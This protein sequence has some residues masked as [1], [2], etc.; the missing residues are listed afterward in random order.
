MESLI[1]N[2]CH[3]VGDDK[4][5]KGWISKSSRTYARHA[6]RNGDR[7][8]CI[9]IMEGTFTNALHTIGNESILAAFY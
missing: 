4:G 1:A 3:A 9:A 2:P 8:D 5:A 7:G 6:I